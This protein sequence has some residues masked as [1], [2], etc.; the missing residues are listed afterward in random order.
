MQAGRRDRNE[1]DLQTAADNVIGK[2]VGKKSKANYNG[3]INTI[4]E[5]L[6][7]EYP[8]TLDDANNIILPL[9]R[10][11]IEKLFGWLSTNTDLP[12]R[13]RGIHR[14]D[15][16]DEDDDDDVDGSME[17]NIFAERSITIS[18]ST[19]GN[20]LSAIVYL[21]RQNRLILDAEVNSWCHDFITGYKNVVAT[22][23]SQGYM[24]ITEGKA[25][26][27]FNG[28]QKISMFLVKLTPVLAFTWELIMFVRL[29]LVMCWNL[30]G[31]S[32]SVGNVMLQHMDWANDLL[33][34]KL[35]KH[36]GDKTGEGIGNNYI[37]LLYYYNW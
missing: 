21:Y 16:D 15:E 13:K 30:I 28:Y 5:F 25:P 14:R 18:V 6:A 19:M 4:K 32:N 22:K 23:K 35:P 31:R 7:T 26:L 29:F 1:D 10:H 37:Y 36:K 11:I 24:S 12:K 9:E 27:S 2:R 33:T 20:Y 34:I 8:N 3:K 17:D